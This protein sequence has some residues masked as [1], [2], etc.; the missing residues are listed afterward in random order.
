MKPMKIRDG[1]L[2][3]LL[4]LEQCSQLQISL[5]KQGF[6]IQPSGHVYPRNIPEDYYRNSTGVHAPIGFLE[7][8]SPPDQGKFT[9]Q[10]LHIDELKSY[11]SQLLKICEDI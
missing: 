2:E 4:T 8:V 11:T 1:S 9:I 10:Y 6:E 5:E 7:F 3:F